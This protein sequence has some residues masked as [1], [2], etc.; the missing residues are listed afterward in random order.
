MSVKS[1][2]SD[3]THDCCS[4]GINWTCFLLW[5][6][7]EVIGA[8]CF[9]RCLPH[10]IDGG[11]SFQITGTSVVVSMETCDVTGCVVAGAGIWD[12]TWC[13]SPSSSPELTRSS[14]ANKMY[15][16]YCH[17]VKPRQSAVQEPPENPWLVGYHVWA[18]CESMFVNAFVIDYCKCHIRRFLYIIVFT[19]MSCTTA[20]N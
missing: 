4:F 10:W 6:G 7:E 20:Y 1:F 8:N 5:K 11:V 3:R 2:L 13:E 12:V 17:L 15:P 18:N 19:N 16:A 14:E 9:K